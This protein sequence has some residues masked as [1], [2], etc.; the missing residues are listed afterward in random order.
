MEN[1]I[2][3]PNH[4]PVFIIQVT[5]GK[6]QV[7][8]SMT[9]CTRGSAGSADGS[10]IGFRPKLGHP[11]HRQKFYA[12]SSSSSFPHVWMPGIAVKKTGLAMKR[13]HKIPPASHTTLLMPMLSAVLLVWK[14]HQNGAMSS[15]SIWVPPNPGP[16]FHRTEANHQ[17]VRSK[18]S[19]GDHPN[20]P[21]SG[22]HS[23]GLV[24]EPNPNRRPNQNQSCWPGHVPEFEIHHSFSWS[25]RTSVGHRMVDEMNMGRLPSETSPCTQIPWLNK[26]FL[27]TFGM[28]AKNHG[29]TS[30][31]LLETPNSSASQPSLSVTFPVLCY[32]KPWWRNPRPES[33]RRETAEMGKSPL[34]AHWVQEDADPSYLLQASGWM[35]QGQLILLDSKDFVCSTLMWCSSSINGILRARSGDLIPCCGN[36]PADLRKHAISVLPM[37]HTGTLRYSNMT[38]WKILHLQMIPLTHHVHN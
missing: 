22:T 24:A 37:C 14:V 13:I 36:F 11:G 15:E 5:K 7:L 10:E 34:A 27:C 4:Q 18:N 35:V 16:E 23:Q 28:K 9:I 6:L 26:P 38:C 25:F 17:E 2:H 19:T 12:S 29:T 3:V 8:M 32:P 21:K 31:D 20:P 1:K 33:I 30:M